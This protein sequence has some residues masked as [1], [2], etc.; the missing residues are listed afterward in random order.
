MIEIR[1]DGG[2]LAEIWVEDKL[3]LNLNS[4]DHDLDTVYLV[5]KTLASHFGKKIDIQNY[6][7]YN[8]DTDTLEIV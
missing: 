7:T 1:T 2:D 6:W 5:A 4:D 3:V 8:A